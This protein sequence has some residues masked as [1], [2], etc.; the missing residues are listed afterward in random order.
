MKH[1][2][3]DYVLDLLEPHGPI[4]ARSLF[5]GYGIYYSDLIIGIIIDRQLYFKVDDQLRT[6]FEV[7]E[8][9][10]FVYE[11]KTKTVAMPY[12]TVPESILEN[13]TTLPDWIKKSYEVALRHNN[14]KKKLPI[15]KKQLESL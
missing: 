4:T 1:Q 15:K 14:L 2:Y 3:R 10:P 6:E 11:G 9:T 13:S 8:S 5:G 12:M 7:L